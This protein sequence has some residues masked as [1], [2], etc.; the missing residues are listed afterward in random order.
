M[1]RLFCIE[2]AK[3]VNETESLSIGYIGTRMCS[4]CGRKVDCQKED[5]LVCYCIDNSKETST[6]SNLIRIKND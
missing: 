2:C 4:A 5:Y 1:T 3:K 6:D